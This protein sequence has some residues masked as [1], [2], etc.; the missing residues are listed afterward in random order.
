[1]EHT[2]PILLHLSVIIFFANIL[3]ALSK[4]FK[5]PPVIGMLLLGIVLGP[6]FIDIVESDVIIKWLAK[7]GVLFLLFEAGLETNLTQIV[8]D[9]KQAMLPALGGILLPLGLG[10]GFSF[11]SGGELMQNLLA[12]VIFT[13]TS[14]SVSVMTLI[15]LGKL[16]GIEGRCIINA[17]IIDDILGILMVTIMFGLAIE[18]EV[19]EA[20]HSGIMFSMIKIAGFFVVTFLV[21]QFLLRPFF[22]NIKK[23]YLDSALISLT[24]AVIFLYSWMAEQAG[25]AAITGAYFAGLFLGQTNFRQS[26]H[27]GVSTVGKSFFIHVFFVN[28][29]LEMN[30]FEIDS[31]PFY[32]IAFIFLAVFG[33]IIGSGIGAKLSGFDPIRSLRIG[34]GMVPRGEVALIIANMAVAKGLLEHK[35]LSAT[36]LTV[37]VSALFTPVM[38]KF[39][40]AKLK[41][42]TF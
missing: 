41:R 30:L 13:A 14:V 28:I 10:A 21:G 17:A 38:L 36:I 35:I 26:I 27:E 16:K 33:K 9:S 24:M 7:L 18:G 25:I 15:D 6:S 19:E 22:R 23:I 37:I 3:T 2:G 8:K 1:M 20:A 32:L 12:G 5:Q 34:I 40:F 4:K 42:K 31:H 29:G 11:L 39:S